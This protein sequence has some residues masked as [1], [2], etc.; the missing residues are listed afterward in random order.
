MPGKT[1]RLH[2]EGASATDNFPCPYIVYQRPSK[3]KWI[4]PGMRIK[5]TVLK[6]QDAFPE[7]VRNAVHF[8]ETPLTVGCYPCTEQPSHPVVDNRGIWSLEKRSGK[9]KPEKQQ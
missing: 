4:D 3:G 8:R 1:D 6:I 7:L 9:A 2:G 5:I